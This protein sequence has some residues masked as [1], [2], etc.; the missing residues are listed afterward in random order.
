MRAVLID[1]GRHHVVPDVTSRFVGLP[2]VAPLSR[3]TVS[4]IA[5]LQ[6]TEVCAVAGSAD[7]STEAVPKFT[8]G[9]RHV[10]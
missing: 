4:G 7:I 3:A 6:P 1:A 9:G 2:P 5:A 10:D 8:L